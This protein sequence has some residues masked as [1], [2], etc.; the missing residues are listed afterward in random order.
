VTFDAPAA[1]AE[2]PEGATRE[3]IFYATNRARYDAGR[4]YLAILVWP[5]GLLVAALVVPFVLA[6]VLRPDLRWPVKGARVLGWGA[7]VASAVWAG[8]EASHLAELSERLGGILYGTQRGPMAYGRCTVSFPPG[9]VQGQ[10][11]RPS[12]FRLEFTEDENK[13]VMV[14]SIEPMESGFFDAVEARARDG[15]GE[16]LVFVHG[17]NVSFEEGA[18]RCAQIAHDLGFPGAPILFSW[19]SQGAYSK[20]RKDE[21]EAAWAHTDL[22]AFLKE[23]RTRTGLRRVHLIAHSMGNRVLSAALIGLK[24]EV[25]KFDEVV[26]AAPDVDAHTFGREVENHLQHTGNV[27]LYASSN[28]PALLASH[29]YY[30]GKPRAGEAGEALIVLPPDV[31]ETVDVSAVS[32]GHSYIGDNGGVLD[33]L[34]RTLRG[35]R[36]QVGRLGLAPETRDG[37]TYWV[38]GLE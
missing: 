22:Y 38:L 21:G 34:R 10:L 15:D 37:K 35:E 18:L 26:M 9:H 8:G 36:A 19:P 6:R 3:E 12:I 28:D 7:V 31:M 2:A 11:E 25:K 1:E 30:H 13:H 14:K 4:A 27:T 20:Y 32:T 16:A 17:F 29:K 5:L 23:L 33:D 24:G